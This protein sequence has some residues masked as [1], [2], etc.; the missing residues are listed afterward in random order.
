MV[1]I[2]KKSNTRFHIAIVL[3]I[4]AIITPFLFSLASSKSEQYWAIARPIPSGSEITLDDIKKIGIRVDSSNHDFLLASTNL[5]GL[6]TT[7]S[8]LANEVVDVRYLRVAEQ[9][10]LEE[11]SVAVSSSDI[12]MKTKVGDYVSIF[13][14]QD[15]KNGEPALLPI[16][17]LT[18]VFISDLDRKGSNFGNTISLTLS[19]NQELVPALL[20]ASS[21][22]RLVLVGK[23]G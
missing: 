18:G 12:P 17:I 19:L 4:L 7:R 1:K 5:I 3:F 11:V 9:S 6:V 20:A 22:G 15:A 10:L 2:E 14:L 21:K 16:R 8:F 23:N 13:L